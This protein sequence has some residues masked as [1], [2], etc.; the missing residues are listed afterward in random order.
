MGFYAVEWDLLMV[1]W[2]SM[3]IS[4]VVSGIEWV[5]LGFDGKILMGNAI[6]TWS[7]FV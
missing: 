2:D 5:L 3:D 7:G 1:E 6:N 4:S